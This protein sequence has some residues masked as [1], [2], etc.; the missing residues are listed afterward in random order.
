MA[1]RQTLTPAMIGLLPSTGASRNRASRRAGCDSIDDRYLVRCSLPR[2]ELLMRS[3]V[4]PEASWLGA[5][6]RLSLLNAGQQLIELRYFAN[7]NANFFERHRIAKL[8]SF[9]HLFLPNFFGPHGKDSGRGEKM[10]LEL[11]AGFEGPSL[12]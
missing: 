10:Q 4:S 9:S 5:R 12:T 1:D 11:S 8:V 7:Q 6:S 3:S 2:R